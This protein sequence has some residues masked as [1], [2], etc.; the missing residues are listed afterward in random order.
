MLEKWSALINLGLESWKTRQVVEKLNQI[1]LYFRI[2]LI[3]FAIFFDWLVKNKDEF[4]NIANNIDY[5]YAK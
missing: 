2:E 1:F 5:T 3:F 4:R